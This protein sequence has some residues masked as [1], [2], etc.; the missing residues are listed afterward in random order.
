MSKNIS[1]GIDFGTT[2][3]SLAVYKNGKIHTINIDPISP[4]PT[5]SRSVIY[6]SPKN[7]LSFGQQAINN[8]NHAIE[9]NEA[10]TKVKIDTGRTIKIAQYSAVGGYKGEKE[11]PEIIEL[12][13]G[14]EGRLLQ[15]I[16]SG[17]S[18]QY[19]TQITAFGH[20]YEII[21]LIAKYLEHIKKQ[22][23]NE[24]EDQIDNAA[25]GRPVNYV[26]GNNSIAIAKMRL[27]AQKAGFKKIKFEY[28]QHG[29]LQNYQQPV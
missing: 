18:K 1:C 16:K 26:G 4:N 23:E 2:N 5:I 11:V 20:E 12:E 6:I 19:F 8:Y 17:L 21:D 15:S 10:R 3:T 22:A 13:K 24:I 7:S 25:I 28:E 29:A 14:G 9:Q 27:A